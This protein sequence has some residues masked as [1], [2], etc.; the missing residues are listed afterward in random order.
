M[1]VMLFLPLPWPRP[2]VGAPKAWRPQG[3]VYH[4]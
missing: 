1:M 4:R 3:H 2:V